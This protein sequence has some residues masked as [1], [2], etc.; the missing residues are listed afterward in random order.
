MGAAGTG[1]ALESSDVALMKDDLSKLVEAVKLSQ[2]AG[3][4]IRQNIFISLLI[5]G[6]FVLLAPF[7]FVTLWLA[8]LADMGTSLVVTINGLRLFGKGR[9]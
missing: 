9:G 2:S 1:V 3:R 4:V 7:G 8:V 6:T 5:K